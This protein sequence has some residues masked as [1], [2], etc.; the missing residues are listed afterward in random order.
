M[1]RRDNGINET[2]TSVPFPLRRRLTLV[3]LFF[4]LLLM[5]FGGLTPPF[6]ELYYYALYWTLAAFFLFVSILVGIYDIMKTYMEIRLLWEKSNRNCLQID[7]K[8]S[9]INKNEKGS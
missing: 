9:Q 3:L 4:S 5:I 1:I 7:T 2:Q 8:E 6:D